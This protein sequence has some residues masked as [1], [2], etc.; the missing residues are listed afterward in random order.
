MNRFCNFK[1]AFIGLLLALTVMSASSKA[2]EELHVQPTQDVDITYQVTRPGQPAGVERRRWSASER[3]QRVDGPKG[4]TIFNRQREEFTLLNPA[5][6]TYR[7]LEGSP[8]M[9][10][11]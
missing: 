11:A 1:H 5:N 4:T 7:T 9:P 2:E 3:L 8:R 6:K 10:M